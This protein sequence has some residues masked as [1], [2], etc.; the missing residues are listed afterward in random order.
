MAK[1]G[2]ERKFKRKQSAKLSCLNELILSKFEA[3]LL[4]IFYKYS[5]KKDKSTFLFFYLPGALIGD[6]IGKRFE[7]IWGPNLTEMLD[8]FRLIKEKA[9]EFESDSEMENSENFFAENMKPYSDDMTL[10]RAA[11]DSLINKEDFDIEDMAYSFEQSYLKESD[12]GFS[13]AAITLFRKLNVLKANNELVFKCLLPAM[14]L[15]N[16]EGSYGN[17]GGKRYSFL[18][19]TKSSKLLYYIEF[20]FIIF[21]ISLKKYSI[22]L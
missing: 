7:G 9:E 6:C 5:I 22:I 16:G 13:T 15:F 19:N 1:L 3:T 20:N 2:F 18:I 12:R 11:C 10:T 8:E 14:E 4:G 17:G 21:K